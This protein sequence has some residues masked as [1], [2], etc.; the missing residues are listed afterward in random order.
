LVYFL[1]IYAQPF[2]TFIF[3]LIKIIPPNIPSKILFLIPL[4]CVLISLSFHVLDS[5]GSRKTFIVNQLSD[6]IP[7]KPISSQFETNTKLKIWVPDSG[8]PCDDSPL[9]CTI[10][11]NIQITLLTPGSISGRFIK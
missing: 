11:K 3:H 1:I 8:K 4:L 5:L 2:G 6:L 7:A 9:P 10:H